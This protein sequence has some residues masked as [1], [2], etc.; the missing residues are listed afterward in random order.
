MD[1]APDDEKELTSRQKAERRH[2]TTDR[3]YFEPITIRFRKGMGSYYDRFNG[4]KDKVGI[5]VR[6]YQMIDEISMDILNLHREQE[7]TRHKAEMRRLEEQEAIIHEEEDRQRECRELLIRKKEEDKASEIR[8]KIR[9]VED[10]LFQHYTSMKNT[11]TSEL[12]E[13]GM[14]KEDIDKECANIEDA[15]NAMWAEFERWGSV[16]QKDI[17]RLS[18]QLAQ[19]IGKIMDRII[20]TGAV[21]YFHGRY[22]KGAKALQ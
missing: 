5:I 6:Y 21:Q 18:F 14:T 9:S 22:M 2:S 10:K 8:D 11:Y 16:D 7:L 20:T 15:R 4:E 1:D 3:K 12:A 19:V 17:P 13:L